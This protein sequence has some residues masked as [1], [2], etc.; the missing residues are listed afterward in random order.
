MTTALRKH[1]RIAVL[2]IAAAAAALAHWPGA[3][4]QTA[5][6]EIVVTSSIIPTDLRQ[7]GAAVGVLP[8]EEIE[9]RG[10]DLPAAREAAALRPVLGSRGSSHRR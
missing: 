7:V 9:L 6:E 1:P 10:R 2:C 8:G 3:A 4:Q 5:P